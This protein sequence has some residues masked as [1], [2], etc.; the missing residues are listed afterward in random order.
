[1][2]LDPTS[3]RLYIS[4]LEEGTIAAAAE[5]EHIAAAAISKRISELESTLKTTL[6]VRTNKGISPTSAG[7]ALS[8][9][10]R[11]VLYELEDISLQMREYT[12]GV[13]GFIRVFANISA[14]N[15]FLPEDIRSFT[16]L[17]PNVQ[18]VLEES[19][20]SS[21]V[22][23]VQE[24]SADIGIFSSFF[25]E[26]NIEILPYR[27]DSLALIAPLGHPILSA[28]K[29]IFPQ[30][31]DYEF[32][33]MHAGSAINSIIT[34]A[35]NELHKSFTMKVRVTGFDSLCFMVNSDL[36]L[37]VLPLA[38]AQRYEKIF[39]IGIIPLQEPW[40]QR[41]LNI[42]IRSRDALST[43]SKLFIDHLQTKSPA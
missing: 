39:N 5:R 15:Q 42:C 10:A 34:T 6:L 19:I 20:S 21:I 13:R 11:R 9:M 31:L 40:A 2:L 18:V 30:A 43:A 17:Y 38:L 32:I 35:A 36:G 29:P 3:L 37:G 4:V 24:N 12:T 28:K 22:K 7:L 1:M 8:E 25:T 41:H 16:R 33:G 14:I 23:S 26:H 27:R